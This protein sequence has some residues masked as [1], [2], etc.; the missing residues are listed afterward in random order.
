M[1]LKACL[2]PW[3]ASFLE[4]KMNQHPGDL[5]ELL[6]TYQV[7]TGGQ[8]QATLANAHTCLLGGISSQDTIFYPAV[9]PWREK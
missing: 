3:M 7:L 8:S 2:F 9:V 1:L 5:P 6:S 4:E